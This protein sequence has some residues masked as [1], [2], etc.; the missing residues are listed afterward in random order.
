MYDCNDVTFMPLQVK[1]HFSMGEKSAA[2]REYRHRR[3]IRRVVRL[4]LISALPALALSALLAR[5]TSSRCWSI[6]WASPTVDDLWWRQV[7]RRELPLGNDGEFERAFE[8][9]RKAPV[10]LLGLQD[11]WPALSRWTPQYFRDKFGDKDVEIY[12][13]GGQSGS[14]LDWHSP[15]RIEEMTMRAF[16]D[17]VLSPAPGAQTGYLQESSFLEDEEEDDD[18]SAENA[19]QYTGYDVAHSPAVRAARARVSQLVA[20]SKARVWADVLWFPHLPLLDP[21]LIESAFWLGGAGVGT[22]IHYDA[23]PAFLH[24]IFGVKRVALWPPSARA[25]LAPSSK[26]NYGAE[27]S[28]IDARPFLGGEPLPTDAT[29]RARIAMQWPSFAVLPNATVDLHPGETLAVPP[30]WWHAT[31]TLSPSISVAVRVQS[32]CQKR[33]EWLDDIFLAMH[34]AGL[35]KRGH[36][37]CHSGVAARGTGR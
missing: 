22:G 35:Y 34:N 37:V 24:Q 3:R 12:L 23:S 27:L 29:A 8:R 2:G 5:F 9:F 10:V 28:Q 30:G 18:G 33:A 19:T 14:G 32:A 26:Y 7:P 36:C 11:G 17:N 4:A 15:T 25:A 16:V 1:K 21:P 6:D 13:W 31:L 20:P